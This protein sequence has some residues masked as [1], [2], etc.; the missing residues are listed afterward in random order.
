LLTIYFNIFD[1]LSQR[2]VQNKNCTI[3]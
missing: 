3:N 2:D 1:I